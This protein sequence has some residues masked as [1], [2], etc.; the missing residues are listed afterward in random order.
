VLF[1]DGCDDGSVGGAVVGCGSEFF[2]EVVAAAGCVDDD[3]LA[4]L[5]GQVQEGM[6]EPGRQVGEAAFL[7]LEGLVADLDLEAP[8]EDV[9]R[10]LP[11]VVDVQRGAA[12]RRD[13]DGE[14]VEGATGVLAGDLEDEVSSG[15]GLQPQA[16]MCGR[17]LCS[18]VVLAIAI[19]SVNVR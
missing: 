3:D 7:E 4:R 13:F 8:A 9:D 12:V 19:A 11:R 14:V 17:T 16:V 10:L 18:A 5:I 6:R 15:A 2:V 1:E